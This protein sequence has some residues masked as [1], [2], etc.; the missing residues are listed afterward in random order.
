MCS[1]DLR[2]GLRWLHLVDLDGAREGRPVNG[3]IL[4]VIC[5]R[6]AQA[7]ARVQVGGGL[8][9]EAAVEGVLAAGAGVAMLGSA[10]IRRPAF[11][12]ECAARWPGRIGFSLD[13]RRGRPAV[14]GWLGDSPTDPVELAGE[15]LAAGASQLA[16]TDTERDGTGAGPNLDL[17]S[18]FRARFPQAMLIAAGGIGKAAD[19]TALARLRVDGAIVGRALLDGSLELRQALA[20]AAGST[21][22]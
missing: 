21:T 19:L 10:A 14:D 20:A 17:V 2:G 15:L 11:V 1:S 22:T 9:D 13:L 18:T 6:A 8:R 4:G 7:G 5:R 12:A 3:R 16:V